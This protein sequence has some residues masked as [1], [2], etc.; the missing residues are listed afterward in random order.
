MYLTILCINR[1]RQWIFA[2]E[3]KT[4]KVFHLCKDSEWPK[5]E[6]YDDRYIILVSSAQPGWTVRLGA[7]YKELEGKLWKGKQNLPEIFTA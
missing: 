6:D 1:I 5:C 2:I 4:C 3:G 7:K